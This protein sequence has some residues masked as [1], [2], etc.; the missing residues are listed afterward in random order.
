M[1]EYRRYLKYFRSKK[2]PRS[3]V[4]EEGTVRVMVSAPHSAE[5]TREGKPKV[6]EYATGVLARMLHDGLSCPVIYKTRNC[7]DDANYDEKCEYKSA[8]AEYVRAHGIKALVDLHQMSALRDENVDIG[9]GFGKNVEAD[10]SVVDR[11]KAC[12]E[13]NGITG[14]FVDEPFASIHP[15]TVSSFISRECGIPCVQIE[16]NTRLLLD[17]Y[18]DF[19]FKRVLK[20]LKCLV[21]ELEKG[22]SDL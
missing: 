1:F 18:R 21:T 16:I 13:R 14:V 8:L 20:A 3:F 19:C 5:Q 17:R 7:L 12:F 6:G 4:I 9:T 11:A 22:I 15:Y 2:D 10:P